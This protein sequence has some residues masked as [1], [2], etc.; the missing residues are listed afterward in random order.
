MTDELRTLLTELRGHASEGRVFVTAKRRPVSERVLYAAFQRAIKA[1]DAIPLSKKE[2]LRFH[3]LRHTV[4]SLLG[5]AGVSAFKIKAL[6]GHKS[7]QTTQRYVNLSAEANRETVNLL[8]AMLSA[9]DRQQP[10]S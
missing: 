8:G 3:D 4:G 9:S 10:S 5:D 2:S 6:L 1:C 7:I